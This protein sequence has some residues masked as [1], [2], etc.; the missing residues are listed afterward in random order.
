MSVIRVD[1][2]GNADDPK[3]P[4]GGPLKWKL[5]AGVTGSF[6][7]CPPAIFSSSEPCFTLSPLT[8][9]KSLTV[10]QKA[11]TI[12]HS[13]YIYEGSCPKNLAKPVLRGSQ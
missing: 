1:V 11:A 2:N 6:C 9:P 5:R 4:Q 8:P 3:V 7:V 10:D 12:T 13:Y